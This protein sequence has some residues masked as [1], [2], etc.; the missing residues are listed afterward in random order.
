MSALTNWIQRAIRRELRRFDDERQLSAMLRARVMLS[1]QETDR[2][3]DSKRLLRY[4]HQV[5]SQGGEDGIVR[6]I[7][8]RVGAKDKTFIELGAGDGIENNTAFL[9]Q[10]GWTG[11]WCEGNADNIALIRR[12]FANELASRRIV[13]VDQMLG[14]ESVLAILQQHLHSELDLLSIDFDR[15][16]HHF[17]IALEALKPRVAVIE[18]NALWPAD[19]DFAVEYDATKIW[20]GSSYFGAS[21]KA[22]ERIGASMSYALVGCDAA[23]TNAFFVRS[24]L[25]G[26]AFAMPYTAENH[27]EPVRYFLHGKL[28]HARAISD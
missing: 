24:D 9:V 12:R 5:F 8:Q 16:T 22:L 7:F 25:L 27:Y 19:L 17:W 28:G 3:R 1:L 6:E 26:D 20:S 11:I 18:Y 2:F 4:E 10:Q 23:G 13:L 14:V 15:H 21:L